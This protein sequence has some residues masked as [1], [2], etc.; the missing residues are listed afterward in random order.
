MSPRAKIPNYIRP[1]KAAHVSHSID[2]S[3]CRGR[4]RFTKIIVGIDQKTGY[5]AKTKVPPKTNMN[6]EG[7]ACALAGI[8]S[9]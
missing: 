6:I 1:E 9:S 8:S 2:Q 4:R 7:R 3:K 5:Q